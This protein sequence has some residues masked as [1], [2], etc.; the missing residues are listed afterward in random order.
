MTVKVGAMPTDSISVTE[1]NR[2]ADAWR[3]WLQDQEAVMLTH[4]AGHTLLPC[5]LRSGFVAPHGG[6]RCPIAL[7]HLRT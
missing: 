4:W 3:D 7:R 2:S 1:F 5:H 6:S